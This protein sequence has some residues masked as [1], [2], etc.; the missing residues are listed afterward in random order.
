MRPRD[1]NQTPF[2]QWMPNDGLEGRTDGHVRSE[3]TSVKAQNG[4]VGTN[5]FSM[6]GN[7]SGDSCFDASRLAEHT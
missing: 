4:L 6:V 1:P 5:A 3:Q 2:Q 7:Q